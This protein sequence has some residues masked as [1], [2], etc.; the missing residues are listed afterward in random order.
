[1]SAKRFCSILLVLSLV[2][3]ASSCEHDKGGMGT[4]QVVFSAEFK[5]EPFEIG[6]VYNDDMGNRI[7]I[8][9]F[10]SYF[11]MLNVVTPEGT[12][13]PVKDFALIN[14]NDEATFTVDLDS[15]DYKGLTFNIG[16]PKEYNKDVDPTT[17]SNDHPLSVQ[18]SQGMF[19]HWNT[20]YIFT[21]FEGKADTT[22]VEGAEILHPFAF[23]V[24]DDPMFRQHN[25]AENFNFKIESGATRVIHVIVDVE[26]I[27]KG[28]G[29]QIDI[30]TD[31][32]THTSGNTQLAVRVMNNFNDAIRVE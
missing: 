27:M 13:I 23:H 19:W 18:G 7:R 16:I 11:S 24:G 29:D 9:N 6:T 31:Y 15:R 22:G 14:F 21:K 32:I 20:G 10:M 2:I 30:A 4:L 26:K 3:F 8:D 12:E 25:E 5:G 17:Y 1:M 28:D